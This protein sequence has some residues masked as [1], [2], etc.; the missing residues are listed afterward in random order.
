VYHPDAAAGCGGERGGPLKGVPGLVAAV[1]SDADPPQPDRRAVR[2]PSRGNQHRARTT[3]QELRGDVPNQ[4][5]AERSAVARADHDGR[6]VPALG[7]VI[8]ALRRRA[9]GDR[10]YLDVA[11]ADLLLYGARGDPLGPGALLIGRDRGDRVRGRIHRCDDQRRPERIGYC[12]AERERVA[13]LRALVHTGHHGMG[14]RWRERLCRFGHEIDVRSRL[15]GLPARKARNRIVGN[16]GF[17]GN[18]AEEHDL[19]TSRRSS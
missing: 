5:T 2:Q 16:Y 19:P 3:G 17:A 4:H 18:P 9:P 6:G 1:E 11:V 13:A 7:E 8:Q 15:A 10:V 12:S 14:L